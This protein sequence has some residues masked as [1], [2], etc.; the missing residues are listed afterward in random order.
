MIRI[1]LSILICLLIACN[2]KTIEKPED[3]I[4]KSMMVEIVYDLAII[5]AAKK[6]N[7]DYLIR[8][9]IEP[10]PFV[11]KKYGV[12]SIQFVKSDIYYASIPSEYEAIYSVVEARLDKEKGDYDANKTKMSDSV[13]KVADEQRKKLR[14]EALKRRAKDSLP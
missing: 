14:E 2:E 4:P 11:F 9:E 10:M 7:P 5:N 13:R 1:V 12:D 3:L 8:N 6:T